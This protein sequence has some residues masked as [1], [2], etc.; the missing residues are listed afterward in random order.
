MA[1]LVDVIKKAAVEAVIAKEPTDLMFGT[2]TNI[3]PLTISIDDKIVLSKKMLI[4]SSLVQDFE[5]E[6]DFEHMTENG[7]CSEGALHNHQYK[8]VKTFKI[9]LGLK[10]GEGVVLIKMAGGQRFYVLDR[11]R[12]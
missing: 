4:L 11:V 1:S 12:N 3:S 9:L 10:E 8:G 5:V 6:L 2:V 7:N